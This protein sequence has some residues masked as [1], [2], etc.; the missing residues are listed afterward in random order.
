MR[1]LPSVLIGLPKLL[2]GSKM[3]D[4]TATAASVLPAERAYHAAANRASKRKRTHQRN[5][6]GSCNIVTAF[7]ATSVWVSRRIAQHHNRTP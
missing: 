3:I 5:V 4:I 2:A 1:V 6:Y 7:L